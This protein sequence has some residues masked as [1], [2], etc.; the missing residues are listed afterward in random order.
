[1]FM[2]SKLVGTRRLHAVGEVNRTGF[3]E[4]GIQVCVYD[5]VGECHN[6]TGELKSSGF[7]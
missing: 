3:T 6:V 4:F 2:N 1:M 7:G 5:R